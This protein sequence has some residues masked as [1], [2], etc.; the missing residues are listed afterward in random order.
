MVK[1][2]S[3]ISLWLMCHR[4]NSEPHDLFM[5]VGFSSVFKL[6]TPSKCM[7]AFLVSSM[8]DTA[9]ARQVGLLFKK[10]SCLLQLQ[11]PTDSIS[12]CAPAT[13]KSACATPMVSGVQC[14]LAP[15]YVQ[16]HAPYHLR[17]VPL[18]MHVRN[19]CWLLLQR[20]LDS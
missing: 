7:I 9:A 16:L 1:V 2:A 20:L 14:T 13:D 19:K 11:S 15:S 4:Y 10:W 6:F 8:R 17:R 3:P 5:S 18:K 12:S